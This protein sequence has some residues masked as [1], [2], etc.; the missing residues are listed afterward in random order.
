MNT[1]IIT[2]AYNIREK[3]N[4]VPSDN[5]NSS[6]SPTIKNDQR[7]KNNNSSINNNITINHESKNILSFLQ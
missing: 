7:H 6:T 1:Q 5:F 4:P 3:D 2:A